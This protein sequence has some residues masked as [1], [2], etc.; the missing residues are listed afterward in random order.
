VSFVSFIFN[1]MCWVWPL[2]RSKAS[3][4]VG[5]QYPTQSFRC[6]LSPFQKQSKKT[7]AL[8]GH[9]ISSRLQASKPILYLL[10]SQALEFSSISS[11]FFAVEHV[12]QVRVKI[13]N[14][15]LFGSSCFS[16][17]RVPGTVIPP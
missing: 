11:P 6:L 14:V 7:G 17:T 16:S 12:G 2:R 9:P 15:V 13:P 5:P 4:T 8:L 3:P 10:V 1:F